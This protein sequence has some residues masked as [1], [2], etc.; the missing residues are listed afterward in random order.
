MYHVTREENSLMYVGRPCEEAEECGFDN[1]GSK[2]CR[3]MSHHMEVPVGA[4]QEAYCLTRLGFGLYVASKIMATIL[5]TVL[6]RENDVR[7]AIDDT[8]VD[9]TAMPVQRVLG[10]LE[11]FGL[12]AESPKMSD[13]GAALGLR[14]DEG[15]SENWSSWERTRFWKL[16]KMR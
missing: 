16:S 5:K 15:E 4:L 9:Q 14:L 2:I 10:Q 12:T 3:S 7:D 1:C 6:K 8:L 11:R 13:G